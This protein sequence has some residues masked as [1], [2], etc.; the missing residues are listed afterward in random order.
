MRIASLLTAL[1]LLTG[2]AASAQ[3]PKISINDLHRELNNG[4]QALKDAWDNVRKL[5]PAGASEEAWGIA[6][7]IA[8]P[9]GAAVMN[10]RSPTG[11]KLHPHLRAAIR[12]YLGPV[13]DRVTFHWATP[14]LDEWAAENYGI[15]L[16]GTESA[17][18]TYGHD[19]FLRQPRPDSPDSDTVHLVVHELA[20]SLQFEQYGS[21]LTN[22]GYHY[23]K[24][25]KNADQSYENNKLEVAADQTADAKTPLIHAAMHVTAWH[26]QSLFHADPVTGRRRVL[27]PANKWGNAQS[28]AAHGDSVFAVQAD[29]L[30]R[31]NPVTGKWDVLGNPVWTGETLMTTLGDHIYIIQDSTLHRVD[32]ADGKW[33]IIGKPKVWKNNPTSITAHSGSI[34]I[35]E[36]NRLHR[37]DP[38]DGTFEVLGNPAWDGPTLMTSLDSSLFIIQ[39]HSLHKVNPANGAWS[40][41]GNSG[42]W[43][44]SP[45]S[46]TAHGDSIFVIENG[47]LHDINPKS[48]TYRVVGPTQWASGTHLTSLATH[49]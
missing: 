35:V 41:V 38:N 46:I 30:H 48:G 13:A 5:N 15:S 40:H 8:L 43:K 22:F 44:Y 2:N 17:G 36:H 49:Q 9:A 39:N 28:I 42:A 20:H 27:G 47:R 4:G 14:L 1:V 16:T 11:E 3:L 7:K 18:Q 23:F 37:V 45:T 32:P 12:R 26:G 10:R 6:G 33:T 24:S 34:F 19:I 21:N 25:Y 29:R 31:V